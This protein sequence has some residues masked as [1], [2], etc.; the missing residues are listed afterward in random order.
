MITAG[1]NNA[2]AKATKPL[3]KPVKNIAVT[4]DSIPKT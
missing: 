3:T 4:S 1:I 2:T